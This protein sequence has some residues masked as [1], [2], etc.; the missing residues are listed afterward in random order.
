MEEFKPQI[1]RLK[2]IVKCMAKMNEMEKDKESTK[3]ELD[4]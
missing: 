1:C 3:L 2:E 4:L